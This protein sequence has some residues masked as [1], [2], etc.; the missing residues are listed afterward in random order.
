MADQGAFAETRM[1]LASGKPAA[2]R[3]GRTEQLR[4]DRAGT[5]AIRIVYPAVQQLRIELRFGGSHPN[6]PTSQLHELYPPARAFFSYPCPH[7]GCDGHFDLSDA[8]R[9]AID[10][11]SH[12]VNGVVECKGSRPRDHTSR[13]SC[14]LQLH[15]GI[16]AA[17]AK[18]L[19]VQKDAPQAPGEFELRVGGPARSGRPGSRAG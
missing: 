15:Y 8:V 11:D 1:K 17:C 12:V 19:P 6:T 16:R 18:E 5:Q 7:A 9:A 3:E 13:Q 4:R 2:A 10:A 14:L